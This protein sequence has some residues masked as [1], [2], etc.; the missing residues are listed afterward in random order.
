MFLPS[1]GRWSPSRSPSASPPGLSSSALARLPPSR[2]RS[3][4]VQAF[5]IN[6]PRLIT[7]TYG[8]GVGLAAFAGVWR[9]RSTRWSADG[10]DLIIVVFAVVVIGGHGSI[11]GSILTGFGLGVIEGLTKVFTGSLQHR[12]LHHHG[13]RPADPTGGTL[14][15]GIL[16]CATTRR[17]SSWRRRTPRHLLMAFG[18]MV[19]IGVV[20]P[21]S[22]YPLFAAK[23]LC[24]ALFACAFNLLI[25]YTGMLSFGHAAFFG[26]AA[27]VTGHGAKLGSA[28]GTRHSYGDC[29]RRRPGPRL[30]HARYPPAGIYFAM[31]TR[32]WRRC[33]SSSACRRP[34]PAAKTASRQSSRRDVRRSRSGKFADALL[35]RARHLPVRLPADLPYCPLAFGQVLKAIRENET[36]ATSLGYKADQYKLI[37]FVLSAALSGLAGSTKSIVF[38]LASL[39]DVHWGMSGEVVLMTLLGGLGT[40]FGPVVGAAILISMQNYLA[41]LGGWVIVVQGVIFVVCV[42]TFRRGVIGEL[43]RLL[44]KPL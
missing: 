8:F 40:M 12:R 38:Q 37:A 21:F 28:A 22:I 10:A 44:K 26:F 36:R 39:T 11:M 42:L 1:S 3:A 4:L 6:V 9:R 23:V 27:Y 30:R 24:F 34:S 20:A 35:R 2:N 18:I 25:G 43:A 14:W 33:C 19:V 31:I 16:I 15:P 41:Q 29:R 13:H 32:P 17:R 5:G 7:I